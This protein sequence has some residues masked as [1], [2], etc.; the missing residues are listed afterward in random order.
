MVDQPRRKFLTRMTGAIVGLG[1]VIAS[2]PLLRSLSP[3]VL[4]EPPRRFKVGSPLDFQQGVTYVDKHRIYL[5]HEGGSFYCISAVC[6]HLGC[7]VSFDNAETTAIFHPSASSSRNPSS[8]CGGTRADS[9][10][11]AIGARVPSRSRSRTR[12]EPVRR[13]AR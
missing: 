4:Y 9:G 7:T 10:V 3:N 11:G 8:V 12:R 1:G 5:F 13:A 2:W 6:S